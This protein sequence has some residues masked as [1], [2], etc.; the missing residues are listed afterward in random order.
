MIALLIGLVIA[1]FALFC[2]ILYWAVVIALFAV[3]AVFLFWTYLFIDY[4][5]EPYIALPCAVVATL[6]TLWAFGA[7]TDYSDRKKAMGDSHQQAPVQP[8]PYASP[9]KSRKVNIV[10]GVV[11]TLFASLFSYAVF[12]TGGFNLVGAIVGGLILSTFATFLVFKL[13]RHV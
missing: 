11:F 10:F 1:G 2:F 9:E 8:Y 6:L 7:Y 12:I 3:G 5:K 4:F 13:W